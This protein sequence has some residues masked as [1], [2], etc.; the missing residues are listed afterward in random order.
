MVLDRGSSTSCRDGPISTRAS[1]EPA[2]RNGTCP[3][4]RR[5]YTPMID[6]L[7]DHPL[8]AVEEAAGVLLTG[9]RLYPGDPDAVLDTVDH[10]CDWARRHGVVGIADLTGD[11]AAA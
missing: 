7:A 9:L 6:E 4:S 5:V 1:S 11:T 3:V 8:G 2:S 10:I